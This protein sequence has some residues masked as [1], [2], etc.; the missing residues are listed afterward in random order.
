MNVYKESFFNSN[1]LLFFHL[2]M[3]ASNNIQNL[4]MFMLSEVK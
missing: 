4:F 2:V 1:E 3:I